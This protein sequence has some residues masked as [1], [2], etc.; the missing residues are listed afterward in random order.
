MKKYLFLIFVLCAS[1]NVYSAPIIY[2][3]TIKVG[4]TITL[5]ESQ[6]LASN[7]LYQ[8]DYSV[9]EVT[10]SSIYIYKVKGL[11]TGTTTLLF[12]KTD[13]SNGAVPV[14]SNLS[15][16]HVITVLD[17]VD[18]SIPPTVNLT[19]EGS[20]AF[21]PIIKDIGA[22][23]TLTWS[24]SNT[25]VATVSGNGVVSGVGQGVA[26]ITCTASNGVSAQSVVTVSP[27][28]A[29]S[30]ALSSHEEALNVGDEVKLV[31]D[32]M[33]ANATSKA[34]K[35]ISTNENIAQ[36]DDAGNVTA[37]APGYCSIFCIADDGSKK[38]DKCL[39]HVQGESASRADVNGDGKV[40]VTDAFSVID[41]I[42]NQ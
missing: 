36:V 27:L 21:N 23:T 42:L 17:V 41:V 12:T 37:L 34:V 26:T 2:Y 29:Q 40:S 28:L 19:V 32:I 5:K 1:L 22:T 38:Y 13:Y 24:S 7:R 16:V 33:P 3:H 30:V 35:W 15:Y 39:V 9:A 20:Y 8:S 6:T 31:P 25:A 18:I 14:Y 4:E 10:E 11:K